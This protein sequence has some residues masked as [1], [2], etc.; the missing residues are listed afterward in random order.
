[1]NRRAFLKNLS[2]ISASSIPVAAFKAEARED[3][4]RH[5][6]VLVDTTRCLGCRSCEMACAKAHDLPRP[7]FDPKTGYDKPR[8]MSEI[9]WTAVSRYQTGSGSVYVKRQCM[10]CFQPA[11]VAACPTKA[12][13]KTSRG[14]VIWRENKCMGCRYCMI[15]C[16]FDV[17]RF[18][19]G[20]AVP[21]IQKCIL[22]WYRLEKGEQ[23][24]CVQNCVGK[25]LLF[26]NR[27]DLLDTAKERIY[28][29]RAK[30]HHHIYG[31]HE[32]GGTGWIYTSSVPFEQIGFRNDLGTTAYPEY[33]RQ[34]LYTV[35]VVLLLWPA[36]LLALNKAT[37]KEE[38]E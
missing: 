33:T 32:V 26:G 24:A 7:D 2:V 16:P 30:Y 11:C 20:S 31:E 25:A 23:P 37:E 21:R 34:F 17:P 5:V 19:F 8:T 14:P 9:Q 12:M 29:N 18:E 6:G 22:C 36:M 27:S 3:D 35:P 4:N 10:H 28:K 1:M 13:Y 15:S 38:E